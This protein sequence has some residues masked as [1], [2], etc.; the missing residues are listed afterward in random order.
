[1]TDA[2]LKSVISNRRRPIELIEER[3]TVVPF[4]LPAASTPP[5]V[6]IRHRLE[7]ATDQ[8]QYTVTG[9]RTNAEWHG[10]LRAGKQPPRPEWTSSFVVP[11]VNPA[12]K[13]YGKADPRF[14][15]LGP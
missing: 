15:G 10:A 1:L 9:R 13:D 12:V 2:T 3:L 4:A 11:G 5:V 7:Y 14:R 6:R 8:H